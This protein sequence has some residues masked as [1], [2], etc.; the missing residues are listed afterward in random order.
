MLLAMRRES[1][2]QSGSLHHQIPISDDPEQLQQA[3]ISATTATAT[4]TS[5]SLSSSSSS[6]ASI[7]GP[8]SESAL[9]PTSTASQLSIPQYGFYSNPSSSGSYLHPH[10]LSQLP[11]PPPPPPLTSTG[12]TVLPSHTS[13]GS[14]LDEYVDILQVQ[15]LLLDSSSG[16]SSG[17]STS[18]TAAAISSSQYLPKPLPRPRIN[19]QKAS[20]YAAQIQ[21]ESPSSR[22]VL[23]DYPSPY[24]Y[25]NHY[26]SSPN[27]DL[28][29]L[30][31][32]SNGSGAF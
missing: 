17:T 10:P 20:E 27:E 31:F 24:L 6:S 25:G 7:F 30:W 23:L 4:T 12:R 9:P 29:A 8:T 32:G 15:Q 11:L 28:V 21:A 16:S 1:D 18:S 19:L 22:R 14:G 3:Q 5:S 26:H 2:H 13:T